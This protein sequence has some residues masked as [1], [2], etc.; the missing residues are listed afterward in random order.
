MSKTMNQVIISDLNRTPI[1]QIITWFTL[2][3]SLLA[4]FTHAGIK[5]YVFRSLTIESWLVLV[6]LVNS[7]S[8]Y[9]RACANGVYQAF[10]VAQ[11][12]AVSLQAHYGFGTPM[13]TLD[14]YQIESNLKVTSYLRSSI[15]S[16][17]LMCA[18]SE[19]AATILFIA[20]LGFSKLAVVAFVHHL[21]PSE[22]HRRI[23]FGVLALI[24]LWLVCS[25]LV[26]AFECRL[27]RP[28]DRTLDRC[29]DRVSCLRRCS[30]GLA[31]DDE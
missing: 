21:T 19:Y 23:N 12:V 24:I 22:L 1:V 7:S 18:K 6:A 10:C 27:P 15:W 13:A 3:T 5:F 29:I 17:A 20:S 31:T 16:T 25:V 30:F 26:A 8:R 28:W 11:S 4:F 2:V 14:G 9:L